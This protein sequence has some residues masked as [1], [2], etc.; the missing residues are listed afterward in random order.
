MEPI[1]PGWKTSAF[2]I[3]LTAQVLA[4]L[5]LFGFV[6]ES[7][8]VTLEAEIGRIVQN[9]F[10]LAVSVTAVWKYIQF[11]TDARKSAAAVQQTQLLASAHVM[12]P[13][14]KP[15]GVRFPPNPVP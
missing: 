3:A 4:V 12:A 8:R 5:V 14:E 13:P 1:T 2:W 11:R 10:A 9:V 6:P 7:D 15:T